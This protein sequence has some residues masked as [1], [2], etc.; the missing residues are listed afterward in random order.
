MSFEN[1]GKEKITLIIIV[2]AL[3]LV[4]GY[5]IAKDLS[6]KDLD[7]DETSNPIVKI[8]T[9]TSMTQKQEVQIEVLKA[10]TGSVAKN[11]DM[12]E[13]HY[14]G[15]LEDGTK[16]DSSLDRNMPFSFKLGIGQVIK[17]WDIGVEGMKIGEKRKLTIPADLAYGDYGVPQANIPAKAI[18]IFEVELLSIN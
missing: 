6:K 18:L 8:N 12:V 7:I 13:V 4:S 16:F 1:L 9:E 10:G 15:T 17:G 5:F 2:V 14:T 11:N 3:I